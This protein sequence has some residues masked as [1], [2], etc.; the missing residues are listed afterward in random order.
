VVNWPL[1]G[2]LVVLSYI[3][4]GILGQAGR[5]AFIGD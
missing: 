4:G 1:F 2:V 3:A 5:E